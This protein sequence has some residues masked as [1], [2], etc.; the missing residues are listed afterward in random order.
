MVSGK[1]T[2]RIPKHTE[3]P[4]PFTSGISR[5]TALWPSSLNLLLRPSLGIIL[6]VSRL[7]LQCLIRLKWRSRRLRRRTAYQMFL[8]SDIYLEYV[9]TGCENPSHVNPNGLG[10]LKLV[11]GYLPTLN[12]EEE[13]S[14][15]DFKAKALATVVGLSAKALRSPPSLLAVE[16]LEKGY[17]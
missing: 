17:R 11:C 13:W 4:K 14:C 8:T 12:E 1:W 2:S 15:N 9:R 6:S 7:T 5:T 16:T 3:L 10:S